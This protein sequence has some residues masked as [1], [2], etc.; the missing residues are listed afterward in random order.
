MKDSSKRAV[1][2]IL[3]LIMFFS[4]AGAALFST[5]DQTQPQEKPKTE[6]QQITERP[7]TDQERL[8][9][10]RAGG[11]IV[12]YSY[13]ELNYTKKT[14]IEDF[15]IKRT[16]G[17]AILSEYKSEDDKFNMIGIDQSNPRAA[18]V[19]NLKDANMSAIF[20][21][22]CKLVLT[23]PRPLDC[24]LKGLNIGVGNST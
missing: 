16:D 10:L 14:E 8:V 20:D 18:V 3:V 19:K 2:V 9:I 24:T 4:L 21:N 12:E 17:K 1:G 11:V 13:K 22:F 15:I 5:T 7:L 23:E 6:I